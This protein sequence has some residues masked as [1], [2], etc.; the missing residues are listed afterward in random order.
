MAR[1]LVIFKAAGSNPH[2]RM[3]EGWLSISISAHS[4]EQAER[5]ATHQAKKLG[6][7]LRC[8]LEVYKTEVYKLRPEMAGP[9]RGLVL[10]MD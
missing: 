7:W 4:K 1:Y 5:W 8:Y 2:P 9:Y 6:P 10:R 3:E